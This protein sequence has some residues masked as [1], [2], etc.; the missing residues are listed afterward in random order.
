MLIRII[1]PAIVDAWARDFDYTNYEGW[2]YHYEEETVSE[3]DY[4]FACK[5]LDEEYAKADKQG[6]GDILMMSL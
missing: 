4:T 6:E 3:E 1:R 5:L 2:A